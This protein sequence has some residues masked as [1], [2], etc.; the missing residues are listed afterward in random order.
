MAV[1][2]DLWGEIFDVKEDLSSFCRIN[3]NRRKFVIDHVIIAVAGWK[4]ILRFL[5]HQS[6]NFM[7]VGG[8]IDL[9]VHVESLN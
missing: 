4:S 6:E 5:V 9:S 2:D 3:L 7:M 1:L 8:N